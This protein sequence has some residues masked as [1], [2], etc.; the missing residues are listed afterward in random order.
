MKSYTVEH[1]IPM[2]NCYTLIKDNETIAVLPSEKACELFMLV[3]EKQLPN[4]CKDS[5]WV[6]KTSFIENIGF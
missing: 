2:A 3:F 5:K 4:T 1:T 6:A